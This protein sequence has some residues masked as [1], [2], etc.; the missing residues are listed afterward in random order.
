MTARTYRQ[1]SSSPGLVAIV[2]TALATA[3][4]VLAMSLAHLGIQQIS[5]PEQAPP[6]PEP[7]PEIPAALGLFQDAALTGG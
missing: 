5:R 3:L 2:L 1:A 7:G 6:T 4:L